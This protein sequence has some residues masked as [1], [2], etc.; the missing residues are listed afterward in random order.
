MLSKVFGKNPSGNELKKVQASP[1]YKDG[2]FKN[3][4]PTKLMD[5]SSMISVLWKFMNKPKN[6]FRLN[7]F[8]L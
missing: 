8:L 3:L 6:Y 1:N 5:N 2:S 7:Q 4:E